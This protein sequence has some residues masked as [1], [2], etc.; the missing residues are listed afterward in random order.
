MSKVLHNSDRLTTLPKKRKDRAAFTLIELLVVIA[1]IAI[2][3]AMLL[4]ALAKAKSRA[5]GAT[6]LSNQKQVALAW[7]MYAGDFQDHIINFDTATNNGVSSLPWRFAIPPSMPGTIGMSAEAKQIALLQAG[8]QQG[9]LYQYAPNVNVL[10]CPADGRYVHPVVPNPGTPPGSFA[11]GSYSGAAGMNGTPYSPDVA[12][13]TT[14]AVVHPTAKF[15]WVEENDPRG[16]NEGS[17]VLNLGTPSAFTDSTF[18]DSVAA[19]H[20][21]TSTFSWADGHAESHKWL[22][23]PTVAYALSFDPNK[24]FNPSLRPTFA[25][26]PQDLL[27]LSQGYAT[28]RNP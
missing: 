25:Q 1:I 6:C 23:A 10:H 18:E 2:L 27:F 11:Y 21:N 8:Y 7:L 14:G 15:L 26:S 24:Y 22:N 4:P 19:W 17:W 28:Q 12:L 20:G 3:A 9:G 16:E 5:M 13:K